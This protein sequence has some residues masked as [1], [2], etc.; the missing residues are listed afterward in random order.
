L[1]GV[2]SEVKERRTV[3]DECAGFTRVLLVPLAPDRNPSVCS[4]KS[5]LAQAKKEKKEKKE[6]DKKRKRD[7]SSDESGSDSGSESGS[8]SDS[9]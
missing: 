4:D 2:V 3:S 5:N 9:E 7:D 1:I 6:K 8:G